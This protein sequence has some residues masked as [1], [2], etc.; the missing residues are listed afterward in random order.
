MSS[1]L[2]CRPSSTSSLALR[3]RR[4]RLSESQDV[5]RG[6]RLLCQCPQGTGSASAARPRRLERDL[7]HR[8][9]QEQHEQQRD[10]PVA[11]AA[12]P[13]CLR[14]LPHAP[15]SR[16]P[17]DASMGK[18]LDLVN[19]GVS[20][21]APNENYPRVVWRSRSRRAPPHHRSDARRLWLCECVAGAPG[22]VQPR[23]PRHSCECRRIGR[24]D[25]ACRSPDPHAPLPTNLRSHGR[26]IVSMQTGYATAGGNTGWGGRT[27]D[28]LEAHNANTD[29]PVA[30]AMERPAMYW[31][32]AVIRS[33]SSNPGM[34][35]N[36]K[37]SKG[38]P[39]GRGTGAAHGATADASGRGQWERYHRC[40]RTMS[41][42]ERAR[43]DGDRGSGEGDLG[44][45][46]SGSGTLQPF[47]SGTLWKSNSRISRASQ[48]DRRVRRSDWK[49]FCSLGGF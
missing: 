2:G 31:A 42:S 18:Y 5:R 8:E 3:N 32:G 17:S 45:G 27:L 35:S 15:D 46:G 6:R 38:V 13:Q 14:E 11:A 41:W 30:I 48:L 39:G 44:P 24:A 9:D 37:Y 22:A 10:R 40:S 20:G 12:Q 36:S 28:H 49:V 34:T 1:R 21:G 23:A 25:D 7:R 43:G 47:P 19:S 4:G 33:I 26:Q 16:S 29:F